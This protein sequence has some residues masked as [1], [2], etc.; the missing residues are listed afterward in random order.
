MTRHRLKNY[1]IL[2]V[3]LSFGVLIIEV[4]QTGLAQFAVGDANKQMI[5]GV[6]IVVAVLLD[7]LRTRWG[8]T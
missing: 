1:W 6:V 5:T 7:A 2:A 4:P 3:C 8:Q